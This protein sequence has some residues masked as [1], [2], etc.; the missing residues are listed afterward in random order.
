MRLHL[1]INYIPVHKD[2]PTRGMTL[3]LEIAQFLC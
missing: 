3:K 2:K 1:D